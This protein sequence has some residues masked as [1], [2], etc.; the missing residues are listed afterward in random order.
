MPEHV[1]GKNLL[2]LLCL[3]GFA[4]VASSCRQ[5]SDGNLRKPSNTSE[6]VQLSA[7]V[8]GEVVAQLRDSGMNM[9]TH[10][11][12]CDAVHLPQFLENVWLIKLE[13]HKSELRHIRDSPALAASAGRSDRQFTT[14]EQPGIEWWAPGKFS[15]YESYQFFVGDGTAVSL[16]FAHADDNTVA[17][18]FERY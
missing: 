11:I 6:N 9:P 13:F 7:A 8:P 16:V 18:F 4:L 14:K 1:R 15:K 5:S 10:V 2:G 17:M 12:S 3:L